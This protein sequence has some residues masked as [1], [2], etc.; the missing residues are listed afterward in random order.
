MSARQCPDAGRLSLRC[1][2]LLLLNALF[3]GG[4]ARPGATQAPAAVS[5]R[6]PITLDQPVP[7]GLER[8]GGSPLTAA[9]LDGDGRLDLVVI[10]KDGLSILYGNGDG[11]F[12]PPVNLPL[13]PGLQEGVVADVNGD[14]L[15]DLIFCQFD[16]SKVVVL[17][18]QGGRQFALPTFYPASDGPVG[19]TAADFNGDG[20]PDLAVSCHLANNMVV[21]L[22][23]GDGTF[24]PPVAYGG[25]EFPGTVFSG[26]FNGD[27]K[28][29]LAQVSLTQNAARIFLGDGT[30]RFDGKGAY[31]TDASYAARGAAADFNGDGILDLAI[32]CLDGISI[33]FGDGTGAFSPPV[34]Y[35]GFWLLRS[36]DFDGDGAPDL[37]AAGYPTA[38][39]SIYLN[40]QAGN[41]L[42]PVVVP[43][44]YLV[45]REEAGRISFSRSSAH[46]VGEGGKR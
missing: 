29:D 43:Q 3:F 16:L 4:A 45:F 22:N 28:I 2:C 38:G 41:F 42:P 20:R 32:G 46:P 30:G 17:L 13:G 10:T 7:V 39:F 14:G 25:F 15:P 27:G 1:G 26:D 23:R 44:G 36:G 24:L 37:V 33:L 8:V 35:H 34:R 11:T 5:F 40:R 19:I 6:P 9:D 31:G 12:A 21:L 18:N